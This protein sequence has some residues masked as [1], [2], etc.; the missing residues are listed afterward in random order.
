MVCAR[1]RTET[2]S[3]HALHF[4]CEFAHFQRS[5]SS[6]SSHNN[7]KTVSFSFPSFKFIRSSNDFIQFH[8]YPHPHTQSDS[9][10]NNY[11]H[12]IILK[13]RCPPLVFLYRDSA[14]LQL[15]SSAFFWMRCWRNGVILL[16]YWVRWTV[17]SSSRCKWPLVN[18]LSAVCASTAV[19]HTNVMQ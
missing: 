18:W 16:R 4:Q 15:K 9:N 13:I 2:V 7:G 6:T 1:I 19:V 12:I 11:N 14:L 3:V 17:A 8:I 5:L 10:N